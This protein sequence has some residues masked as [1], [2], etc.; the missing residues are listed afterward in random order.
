[1]EERAKQAIAH[2]LEY[3]GGYVNDP[4]DPGGETNFGISKRSYPQLDIKNLT[5]DRAIKIYFDDFWQ[6][7]GCGLLVDDSL[8]GKVFDLS[9]NTGPRRAHVLLQEAVNHTSPA[10]LNVDGKLGIDTVEACNGHPHPAHLLAELR[11]GA[12][13]FYVDLA[14]KKKMQKFLAG[15][16]RRA[17]A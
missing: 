8:A 15:W 4:S 14:I 17:L 2:T 9:V 13:A 6:P 10:A 3:E 5:R 16:V 7:G 12:I 11:L 1:M